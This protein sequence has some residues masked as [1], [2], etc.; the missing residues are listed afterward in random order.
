MIEVTEFGAGLGII[1]VQTRHPLDTQTIDAYHLALAESTDP[2]QW[3]RFCSVA[4][5]TYSWRFFPGLVDLVEA[6]REFQRQEH[7]RKADQKRRALPAAARDEVEEQQ[8]R[9][10]AAKGPLAVIAEKAAALGLVS[11]GPQ[12]MPTQVKATDAR[13]QELLAAAEK[14]RRE[15]G[16]A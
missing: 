7:Q 16:D 5:L 11:A 4:V 14:N 9:E 3:E 2:E 12:T 8:A 10:V 13:K 1:A 15:A 6:L